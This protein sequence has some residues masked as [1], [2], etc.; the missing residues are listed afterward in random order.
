MNISDPAQQL[1]EIK[2]LRSFAQKKLSHIDKTIGSFVVDFNQKKSNITQLNE[3]IQA[4]QKT[5]SNIKESSAKLCNVLNLLNT[6]TR[7]QTIINS[8]IE[9][10]FDQYMEAM[11]EIRTAHK[12]LLSYDFKDAKE[13]IESILNLEYRGI[14]FIRCYY[15]QLIG[16]FKEPFPYETF[17]LEDNKLKI[18][19]KELRDNIYYPITSKNFEHMVTIINLFKE[20]KGKT[21]FRAQNE[22]LSP[23]YMF[24]TSR[25]AFIN[26]SLSQFL[27]ECKKDRNIKT[28]NINVLEISNYKRKNHP[29]HLF[30]YALEFLVHREM[31]ITER[32]FSD[33]YLSI[34]SSN[35]ESAMTYYANTI[36]TLQKPIVSHIDALFDLDLESTILDVFDS[37]QAAYSTNQVENIFN[38]IH[39]IQNIASKLDE[40]VC[41]VILKFLD[42]IIIHD[43]NYVP[44]SGTISPISANVLFYLLNLLEYPNVLNRNEVL[45]LKYISTKAITYLNENLET[46]SQ[47]YNDKI[48]SSIF[49]LNNS[50]YINEKIHNTDLIYYVQNTV[51]QQLED[52]ISDEQAKYMS[53]TWDTAFVILTSKTVEV[54]PGDFLSKKQC[55]IIKKQFSEFA[56]RMQVLLHA[57]HKYS[58][59]NSKLWGPIRNDAVKKVH[60]IYGRYFTKW[61]DSGFANNPEKYYCF[62]PSTLADRISKQ[63]GS[64][65]K[66]QAYH[67][68]HDS[69]GDE[70][71]SSRKYSDTFTNE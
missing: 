3:K 4:H 39:H 66:A 19:N 64:E 52:I 24:S 36:S 37:L 61:K 20:L 40:T 59:S 22:K 49:I 2:K 13:K 51:L 35:V 38:P 41:D 33:D 1:L 16:L 14:N 63:L 32:L 57:H 42:A 34:V 55:K 5:I 46:K 10:N 56:K 53:L 23:E 58:T 17:E 6:E 67:S 71:L 21:D 62:Q 25:R 65:Q 31:K 30:S 43:P 28:G 15:A 47:K 48:I 50:H 29:I 12:E 27:I 11:T 26:R 8:P 7:L 54:I 68:D 45:T 44:P 18:T 70:N 60:S 69:H 9:Q